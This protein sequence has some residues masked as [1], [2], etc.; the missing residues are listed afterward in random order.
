MDTTSLE[1][2]DAVVTTMELS[3]KAITKFDQALEKI[4]SS[5]GMIGAQINRLEYTQRN[6]TI[7]AQNLT[8]AESRIRDLDVATESAAF[9]KNNILVNAAVAMLAQANQLPQVAL[10]LIGR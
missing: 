2:D 1:I 3:Q 6:L 7:S 8:A 10:Q 4:T 9:A 5:R